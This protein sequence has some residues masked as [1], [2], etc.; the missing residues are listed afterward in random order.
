VVAVRGA[1]HQQAFEV[2]CHVEDLELRATGSGSSRQRAEQCAAA[3]ILE[4]IRA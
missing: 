3:A 4:R 1:A 2:E